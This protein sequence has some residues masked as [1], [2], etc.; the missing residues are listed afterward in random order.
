MPPNWKPTE[1]ALACHAYANATFNGIKGVDQDRESFCADIAL[2]LS[3][4]APKEA[5]PGKE[6][7]NLIAFIFPSFIVFLHLFVVTLLM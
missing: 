4:I 7:K 1:I 3:M 2:K 5:L 6:I